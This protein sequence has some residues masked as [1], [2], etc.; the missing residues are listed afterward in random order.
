MEI[1]TVTDSYPD[2]IKRAKATSSPSNLRA[3]K[4]LGH[5]A[6]YSTNIVEYFVT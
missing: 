2:F 5:N 1:I 3:A 6:K 4:A